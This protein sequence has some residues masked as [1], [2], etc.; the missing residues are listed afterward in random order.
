MCLSAGRLRWTDPGLAPGSPSVSV[1][2]E[3]PALQV[4]FLS[5]ALPAAELQLN[6][7]VLIFGVNLTF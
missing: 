1:T 2:L 6:T 5:S 4:Y 3:T 7:C